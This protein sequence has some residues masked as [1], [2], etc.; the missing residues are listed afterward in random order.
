[1]TPSTPATANAG[2]SRSGFVPVEGARLWYEEVGA[3][4]PLVLLHAGLGDSRMWD[5]QVAAFAPAHRVIRYDARGFG[6]SDPARGAYSAPADLVGL[7]DGLELGRAHLLGLSMGGAVALDAALAFP[8]R[9]ASLVLASA[10][11][12]G[13]APSAVLRDGW[14]AVD[15][16]VEAGDLAGA[17]E[18]ELRM[19]VDGPRRQPGAVDPA[20]R[21]LVGE[22]NASLLAGPDEGE[23]RPLDPPAVGRLAEIAAPTLVIVG[24]LDQPDV[25]AAGNLLAAGIPGAR[26]RVV[27]GTAHLP[28]LER[29]DEF[30]RLIAG[31][32]GEV[33]AAR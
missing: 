21:A 31:L 22:M 23:P 10:R 18:L 32:L 1:M 8:E 12:S 15:E 17:N 9:V 30:N 14:D 28:N 27:A 6:R 19:W 13:L 3:G 5:P 33:G 20:V 4:P 16:A 7:L 11:P 24:D 25:V 2:V 26:L 29:P